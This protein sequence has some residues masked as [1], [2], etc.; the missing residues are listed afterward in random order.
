MKRVVDCIFYDKDWKEVEIS[1]DLKA[2]PCCTVHAFHFLDNTFYDEYLDSL[3]KNWNSLKHHSLD[4]IL[5]T[6]RDYIRPEKWQ[7]VDTSPQC[8][9]RQCLKPEY[10][11]E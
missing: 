5:K 3:P 10:V 7:N 1:S 6:Y 8:C 2:Y 4:D 9:K 11:E